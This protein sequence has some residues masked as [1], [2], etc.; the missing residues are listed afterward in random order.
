MS[1]KFRNNYI[2]PASS[3]GIN[4]GNEFDESVLLQADD[5][6]IAV[7]NIV[8]LK[9]ETERIE[10][11][12][13]VALSAH[14][15]SN[16]TEHQLLQQGIATAQA[17]ADSAH[18]ATNINNGVLPLAQVPNLPAGRITSDR[19]D[20]ARLPTSA[21]ANRILRVGGAGINP[22]YGQVE[23]GTD[24]TG[25]L[26]VENGGTGATNAS[27][28]RANL[29][30]TPAN[31]GAI[32]QVAAD[33]RFARFDGAQTL[34]AAQQT[35]A[36]TNLG[37][38]SAN[39]GAAATGHTHVANDITSGT[40]LLARGGTGASL[41]SSTAARALHIGANATT[42]TAGTLPI[43]A[44]GTGRTTTANGAWF[45]T[46]AGAT[47]P[48]I[49]TLPIA[50]GG[51]NATT[52]AAARTNLGI[53]PAAIG[54]SA[55]WELLRDGSTNLSIL[56]ADREFNHARVG[57]ALCAIE[58]RLGLQTWS[59]SLIYFLHTGD[60]GLVQFIIPPSG[61]QVAAGNGQL[62]NSTLYNVVTCRRNTTTWAGIVFNRAREIRAVNGVLESRHA[63]TGIQIGRIWRIN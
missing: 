2:A 58:V 40:M 47:Q 52:A 23:L 21:T 7:N 31:I 14:T 16:L 18:N 29:G 38:T 42:V 4:D 12:S 54:A 43:N 45:T 49:G 3:D 13:A 5:L 11:S 25:R 26:S 56:D 8:H 41:S 37:V 27:D 24:V 62:L 46:A 22:A 17:R 28:A 6:N 57:A 59:S 19:L 35:Q 51:T 32:T 50:Q 60:P 34:T 36:R 33:A 30:V 61:A 55:A 15:D 63:I 48:T 20:L 10:K 44:G 39:I 9:E 53:T 1:R